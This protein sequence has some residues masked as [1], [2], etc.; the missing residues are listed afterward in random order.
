[1]NKK[2]LGLGMLAVG[3]AVLLPQGEKQDDNA[4]GGYLDPGDQEVTEEHGPD[5]TDLMAGIGD[6]V[7]SSNLPVI[8]EQQSLTKDQYMT[9]RKKEWRNLLQQKLDAG[10]ELSVATQE[11]W[12]LWY[13]PLNVARNYFNSPAS[14]LLSLIVDTSADQIGA[15]DHNSTPVYPTWYNWWN[16]FDDIWT[17]SD[18]KTYHQKLE[19]H[20]G[21]TSEANQVWEQAWSNPDNISDFAGGLSAIWNYT[22]ASMLLRTSTDCRYDCNLMEYLYSKGIDISNFFSGFTCSMENVAMN[23]VGTVEDVSTGIGNFGKIAKILV[24]VGA[25]WL[26]ISWLKGTTKKVERKA[27][28]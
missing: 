28:E 14:L 16:N 9:Y 3:A 21:N 24:P 27:E 15:I 11:L 1:M 25:T 23:I 17:C 10:K 18:W 4:P 20:F 8:K 19:E 12:M 7:P 6:L 13:N 2:A 22:P 26:V 5:R